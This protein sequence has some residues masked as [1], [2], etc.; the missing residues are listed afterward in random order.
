MRLLVTIAHYFKA[1]G[2]QSSLGS[3]D[4]PLPKVAAL[5]AAIAALYRYYGPNR[6]SLDADD[7]QGQSVHNGDVL[8]IVVM[9]KQDGNLLDDI[10]IDKS[11]YSISYCDCEPHM[12]PFEAQRIMRER[13]GRYDMYA[14]MEDDLIVDDPAFFDKIAWFAREFGPRAILL[15]IRYEF[16]S[17]GLPAK[18]SLS[19]RLSLKNQAPFRTGEAPATLRGHW[20]GSEQSFARPAN[21]HAG[22]Y[23]LTSAQLDA[24]IASPTFFDRDTSWIDPLV[25]G[26][27]LSVGKEFTIYMPSAPDPWFLQIEHYGIRL[28]ATHVE[29]GQLRGGPLLLALLGSSANTRGAEQQETSIS[30]HDAIVA[31]AQQAANEAR[32][33]DELDRLKNSPS[34]LLK[35]LAATYWRRV[36]K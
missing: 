3:G 23:A 32:L 30:I 20:R 36:R 4:L 11:A 27:T 13:A 35:T 28:S 18:I 25:S 34:R 29:P 5:N 16:S 33:R 14:Y 31:S 19:R 26:A 12:L 10:G 24:W 7:P 21:P 22:C 2:G 6:S 9:T 17:T 1:S 8:D 15:P